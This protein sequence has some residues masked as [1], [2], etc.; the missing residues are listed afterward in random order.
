MSGAVAHTPR[1]PPRYGA[2]ALPLPR[3]YAAGCFLCTG[4]RGVHKKHNA[5]WS[6]TIPPAV[7]GRLGRGYAE[8]RHETV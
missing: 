2:P 5:R 1:D 7:L 6:A 4:W 3:C 8:L